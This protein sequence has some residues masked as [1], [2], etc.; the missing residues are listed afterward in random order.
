MRAS[1]DCVTFIKD[2][3]GFSS[4][5]Y[6]DYNQYTV[7]Y[8]TKC[9]TEKYFEYKSNGISKKEAEALLR[10]TIEEIE[11]SIKSKLID[12]YP[13]KLTQHQ[14]DALVSFTFNLGSGWMTYDSSLRN[15]IVD[16]AD[17][18]GMVYAFGLY[19]T[20][21]G[22]YLPGLISRRLCE[23]N[24]YLNGIYSQKVSNDYGYVYYDANGGTLTYRVQGFVCDHDTAPAADAKRNGDV[25]LGWYTELSGGSHVTTLDKSVRGKTLFARWQ[26]SENAEI[27]DIV[28]TTVQVTGDVVNVRSG[29]GTNYKVVRKVYQNDVL[30]ISHVSNFTNMVWGKIQQGWICLDYTNY[31]DVINGT[32]K[33]ELEDSPAP[34][35]E[36][37]NDEEK[38]DS[39]PDTKTYVTGI[40]KVNDALRIRSGPGTEYATVGFLFNGKEIDILQQQETGSTMWGNIDKGWICLDY[41][42]IEESY[43]ESPDSEQIN[44]GQTTEESQ[45][46]EDPDTET[47]ESEEKSETVSVTGTIKAD[48]LRIR[49]GPGTDHPIVSFYYPNDPVTITEKRLVGSVYWGKTNIG[50]IN[51]DYFVPDSGQEES[52]GPSEGITKKVTGDCLRIRKGAGS[53]HK[54][55][56]FLYYG[57]TVSILET[58]AAEDTVWGRIEKGWICMDYVH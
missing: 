55:V 49:T 12:R 35:D 47:T 23:A 16:N 26:S 7:G 39:P 43:L 3:E 27:Q 40:V 53:H 48:A 4:Q 24:I 41:V 13:L 46:E 19:C 58:K 29:P 14:F 28:S 45:P 33:P 56:G 20:A 42:V 10:D 2:V 32:E 11:K 30:T 34:D 51:L 17:E 54:I 50:W 44:S 36:T 38:D 57:D 25:F 8:G 37:A 52:D 31:E 6:Y 1:E 18:D 9:P 21:G 5:P 22:K 15:A